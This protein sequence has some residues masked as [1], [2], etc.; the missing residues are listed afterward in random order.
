[1]KERVKVIAKWALYPLFY[2]A[3]LAVFGYLTFPWGRLKDRLVAE[4]ERAQAARTLGR[5]Q[6]RLEIDDLD[7]YWFSGV[8]VKGLRI[9]I[10]PS[11]EDT[12]AA[13]ASSFGFG[14]TKPAEDKPAPKETV[15]AV[16]SA[17]ARV[18]LLPLLIGRVRV[19]FWA[20]AFGGE[21]SGTVPVG[22]S[23]GPVEVQ[24]EGVDLSKVEAIGSVVGVPVKGV[25]SGKLVLSAESGKFSKA[26]GELALN[27]KD[28]SVG[29]GVT[30]IKGQ[31]AL[32]EAKLG[33][34]EITAE[35]TG[36]VLKISKMS[37]PGPD[38]E[39]VGDGK[40]SVKEPWNDSNADLY[41]RFKFSDGY[42]NKND[43]TKSLL[44]APGS[45]APALFELADPKIKKAKRP[46]GFYGWHAHGPLRRLKFDP[47]TTDGPEGKT[48]KKG[49]TPDKPEVPAFGKKSPAMTPPP[50][51]KEKE[52]EPE[53]PAAAAA[54]PTPPP[55]AKEPAPSRELGPPSTPPP[56]SPP[57]AREEP[58]QPVERDAPEPDER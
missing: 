34:I 17:H 18:R 47:S 16:E 2:F 56:E 25:A 15:V 50:R 13:S 30:K 12:L 20:G 48:S 38:V 28:A 23:N 9:Y 29:D 3:C 52:K 55:E 24:I 8:E 44:G 43:L 54:P 45:S 31:I 19:D 26:S 49:K 40:V 6:Q 46:D 42:R 57:A 35:A 32:P 51:E 10:P 4:F 53:E 39:L 1:M 5:A 22:A 21:V 58:E 7:S 37:A 33:D 27:V 36:G 41:V 14:G 11:P